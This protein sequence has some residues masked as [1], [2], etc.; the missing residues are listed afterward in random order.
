MSLRAIK[1]TARSRLHDRMRVETY[2][3]N[4]GPDG[5]RETVFL[6]V[7]S[8]VEEVGDLAGTSLAYAQRGETVPKLIFW[9]ADGHTPKRGTVYAVDT[10]EAYQVDNLEPRDGPTVTAIAK[11]LPKEEAAKYEHPGC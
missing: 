6:R 9:I 7:N 5:D 4:D 8:E 10:D 2:A 3:Y 1:A 11:R